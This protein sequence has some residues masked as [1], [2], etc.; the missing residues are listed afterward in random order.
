MLLLVAPADNPRRR[1]VKRI[2]GEWKLILSKRQGDSLTEAPRSDLRHIHD[3]RGET[4]HYR[5]TLLS[6]PQTFERG[7]TRLLKIILIMA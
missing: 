4:S 6:Q 2:T 7:N 1:F 3:P 5:M